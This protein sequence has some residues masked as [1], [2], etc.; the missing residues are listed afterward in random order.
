VAALCLAGVLVA[1]AV[2][3]AAE[4]TL[5]HPLLAASLEASVHPLVL[6][7]LEVV[8]E[9]SKAALVDVVAD[10]VV[11]GATVA[12]V[13]AGVEV[14][15]AAVVE[16]EAL[17]VVAAV[18]VTSR[19]ATVLLMALLPA[20]A[21]HEREASVA[22]AVASAVIADQVA[23]SEM[24]DEAAG[25]VTIVDQVVPITSLWAAETALATA[26]ETV[27]M[28]AIE[29]TARE[30]VGTKATATTIHDSEGGFELSRLAQ[31]CRR[32]GLSRLPPFLSPHHFS[33]MRVRCASLDS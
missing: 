19:T 22:D 10:V 30:S 4:A 9:A 29:M 21:A 16:A 14:S 32:K 26:V 3:W 15:V 11:L 24:T 13:V 1:L 7:A 27:G 6:A 17:V 33:S 23:G 18:L 25:E 8:A 20:P 12:L 2:V 31:V 28:A 5:R